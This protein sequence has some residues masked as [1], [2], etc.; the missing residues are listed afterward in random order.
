[1]RVRPAKEKRDS[2]LKPKT[3]NAPTKPKPSSFLRSV[4]AE[5]RWQLK[6]QLKLF[7]W[8][9]WHPLHLR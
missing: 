8:Q 6:V 4:K 9:R 5:G 2:E 3:K 1:M 7:G